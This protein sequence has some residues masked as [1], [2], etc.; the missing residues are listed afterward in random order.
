[1]AANIACCICGARPYPELGP[2][3]RRED[4][5][6]LKLVEREADDGEG[7]WWA[8]ASE[9]DGAEYCS[10]HWRPGPRGASRRIASSRG[11]SGSLRTR[12]GLLLSPRRD[13]HCGRA[14]AAT[15]I[16]SPPLRSSPSRRSIRR[17]TRKGGP[18]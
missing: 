13:P 9:N 16:G 14:L 12:Q 6:L 5:E 1:M 11:P 4:F 10:E 18:R 7:K 8:P 17:S 3:G 15:L 2:P